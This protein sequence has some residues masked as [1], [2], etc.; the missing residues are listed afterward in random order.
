M[1]LQDKFEHWVKTEYWPEMQLE[2]KGDDYSTL[3]A[4]TLWIGYQAGYERREADGN[5]DKVSNG[6]G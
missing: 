2:R 3:A 4:R 6:Q 5:V 1:T